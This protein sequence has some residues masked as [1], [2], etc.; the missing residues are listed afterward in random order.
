[1]TE[2][3]HA[4]E[5]A[6]AE[7]INGILKNELNLDHEFSSVDQ[8]RKTTAEAVSIYNCERPHLSLD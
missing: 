4:A 6:V 7:R 2:F 1:M 8:A 5:N 3:D